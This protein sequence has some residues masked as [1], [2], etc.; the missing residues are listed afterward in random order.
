MSRFFEKWSAKF[1]EFYLVLKTKSANLRLNLK[2]SY[3]KSR[4][5]HFFFYFVAIFVDDF[6]DKSAVVVE[7]FAQPV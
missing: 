3:Y 1:A 6:F 5:N 2:V 7:F 4:P